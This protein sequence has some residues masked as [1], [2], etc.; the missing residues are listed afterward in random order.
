MKS[1]PSP[2]KAMSRAP[3]APPPPPRMMQAPH[4]PGYHPSHSR[5][6]YMASVPP[7]QQH[8]MGPPQV[9]RTGSFEQSMTPTSVTKPPMPVMPLKQSLSEEADSDRTSASALLEAAMAMTQLH[10]DSPNKSTPPRPTTSEPNI[11][12]EDQS[13]A[14]PMK[15][16]RVGDGDAPPQDF[17]RRSWPMTTIGLASHEASPVSRVSAEDGFT[18]GEETKQNETAASSEVVATDDLPQGNK[19]VLAS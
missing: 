12:D 7:G 5:P 8:M 11:S 19:E 2:Q 4:P 3:Y 15:R 16:R 13:E 6:P 17:A 18:D 10:K 9:A 1:S 14:P